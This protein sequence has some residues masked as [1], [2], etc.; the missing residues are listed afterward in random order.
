MEHVS[1]FYKAITKITVQTNFK[2]VALIFFYQL[3]Q[4]G[5]VGYEN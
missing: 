4:V 2:S 5:F 3:V 1:K